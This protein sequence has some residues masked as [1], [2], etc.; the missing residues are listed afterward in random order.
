VAAADSP[1]AS[2][3][4]DDLAGQRAFRHFAL[5]PSFRE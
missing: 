2:G 5:S 4:Q 1:S 3:N